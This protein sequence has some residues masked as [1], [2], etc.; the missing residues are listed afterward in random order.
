M[1]LPRC[2]NLPNSRINF[3]RNGDPYLGSVH[4]HWPHLKIHENLLKFTP[5]LPPPLPPLQSIQKS[6]NSFQIY[7]I[8]Q[9]QPIEFD[10]NWI[11]RSIFCCCCIYFALC[12]RVV[13]IGRLLMASSSSSLFCLSFDVFIRLYIR[14]FL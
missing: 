2:A 5:P 8:H 1:L 4:S 11:L 6:L 13:V 10:S 9:Q 14:T 3:Y 12:C 7:W